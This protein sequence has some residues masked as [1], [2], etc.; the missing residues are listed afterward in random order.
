MPLPS[1]QP[2]P[3]WGGCFPHFFFSAQLGLPYCSVTAPF[4]PHQI[5]AQGHRSG[6]K[7]TGF[8]GTEYMCFL[9]LSLTVLPEFFRGP[10]HL[11]APATPPAWMPCTF[12]YRCVFFLKPQFLLQSMSPR[13]FQAIFVGSL[14]NSSRPSPWSPNILVPALE[15]FTS[16]ISFSSPHASGQ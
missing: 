6:E 10:S 5:Q 2:G 16:Q 11:P 12:S 4:S 7:G 8:H 3:Q 15:K 9:T 13:N 1:S 14:Y